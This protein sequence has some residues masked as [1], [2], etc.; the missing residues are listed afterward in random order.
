MTIIRQI[1]I[2]HFR[3]IGYLVWCPQ[4]GINCL[5]GPGDSGKST[6]L[7]AIDLTLGARRQATFT[8]ADFHLL[9][10]TKPIDIKITLGALD[11]SLKNLES[12]GLF[13]RGWNVATG[14]LEPEPGVGLETALTLALTVGDD[15][16]P[17][18]ALFSERAEAQGSSRDLTWSHRNQYA[19]TRLGPYA[20][21]H[22]AWG[23]KSILNRLSEDRANA[24]AALAAAA[25]KARDAFAGQADTEVQRTLDAV[26]TVANDLGVPVTDVQALLDIQGVSFSGGSIAIHDDHRIPLRSLGLGSARLLVAGMQRKAA[27]TARIALIDEVEHGLEPYRI[28]RL[29]NTLGSKGDQ[30][31]AQVFMTTH[32]PVVLRELSAGQLHILRSVRDIRYPSISVTGQAGTPPLPAIETQ[33][34]SQKAPELSHKVILLGNHEADQATL[35]ACAEAFLSPAVLVCEGKTEIGIVRGQDLHEIDAGKRSMAALGVYTADGGGDNTFT[36]ALTFARLG[37]RVAIFRDADKAPTAEHISAAK[38]AAIPT[39]Q[40]EDGHAT[41]NQFFAAIPTDC[42]PLLLAIAVERC[43]EEAV[44]AHIKNASD[45]KYSLS[46]CRD[47]FKDEMRPFLGKAAKKKAW[48]KDIDPAERIARTI[49][50]PNINACTEPLPTI[51]KTIR[52]WI[53]A[54]SELLIG[55]AANAPNRE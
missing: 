26:R 6:I 27:S 43:G 45:Q 23:A 10:V 37:Y 12:Y 34:T 17:N 33:S 42:I 21:H 44:D 55:K 19:P 49:V 46:I 9:D 53:E 47:N 48:F 52:D 38:T 51:F 22:F 50:C 5:I 31:L 20:S 36:R 41:E 40:W 30:G 29:L 54:E 15:L 32:S 3:S 1:E 39:Y 35:R 16:E 14:E 11:D 8:D 2:N 25:R 13:H 18:W 24:A 28:I 4:E 7:D